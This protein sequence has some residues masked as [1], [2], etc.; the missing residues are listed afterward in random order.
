M[1]KV[2][3]EFLAPM[4]WDEF[5]SMILSCVFAVIIGIVCADAAGFFA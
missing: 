3:K 4:D 5:F 1:K 2:L